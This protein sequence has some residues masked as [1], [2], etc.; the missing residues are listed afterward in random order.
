MVSAG[1]LLVYMSL[2]QKLPLFPF[3]QR[4]E[5]WDGFKCTPETAGNTLSTIVILMCGYW[6]EWC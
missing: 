2:L 6:I 1:M 3:V 4:K 5:S